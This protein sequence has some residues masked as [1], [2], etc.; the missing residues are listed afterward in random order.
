MTTPGLPLRVGDL[1]PSVRDLHRRLSAVGSVDL[2]D[3]GVFDADTSEAVRYF[4]KDRGIIVDGICGPQTWAALIEASHQL[5]DRMLYLRSP[6]S[7]GDDVMQLQQQLGALGFDAGWVD[8]I[9]GPATELALRDFQRNQ[10]LTPD[11]VLGLD[12]VRCLGNLRGR[13]AGSKTVA[14]VREAE[15]LR[16]LPGVVSSRRL[17]IGESGGIPSIVDSLAR[18]LKTDGAQVL[19]LHHPDLSVQAKSANEWDGDVFIGMTLAN[20]DHSVAYFATDGFESAGGHALATKCA[21]RLGSVLACE[22][23]YSGLR[24]PILRETRMPAIWCRLGPPALV[25]ENAAAIVS[26]VRDALTEWCADPLLQG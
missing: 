25:V 7:R 16:S 18:R 5:G 14:E 23:P 26:T 19:A 24:L 12:T 11:G 4:Q 13:I 20:E 10:G 6:M 8:G 22:L 9:F 21:S 2:G 17:V 15:A 3:T 1:G